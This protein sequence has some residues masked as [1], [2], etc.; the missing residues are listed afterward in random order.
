MAN[1]P[2]QYDDRLMWAASSR[3]AGL[4]KADRKRVNERLKPAWHNLK[5]Q[6][7]NREIGFL[8]I[9]KLKREISETEALA[10]ALTRSYD[11][12]IVIGI[13]GSDLGARALLRA[14]QPENPPMQVR[15]IGANTDPEEIVHLLETVDL[16]RSVL[17][18]VSKSGGTIEPMSTFLLLRDRLIRAVGKERHRHQVVATT[19]PEQGTLRT[20]VEREGY[21]SL[22]IPP[23]IGGRFS[24][25]TPVGLLPAACAGIDIR[26]LVRGAAQQFTDFL[27][28]PP[29]RNAV[30]QYAGYHHRGLEAGW[31]RLAVLMPYSAALSEIGHWYAQLWA[32]SLGK[33]RDRAGRLVHAGQTPLYAVGATDQHSQVQLFNEGPVDK[34]VTFIEVERFRHEL[35]VPKAYRDLEGLAY[36]GGHQFSDIIHAERAA[37]AQALFDAGRPNG[38]LQLTSV[39]PQ[40]VG[41]LMAF[42]MLAT[43]V[44]GELLDVNAYDQPGVEA[45]KQLMYRHLGRPGF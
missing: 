10:R 36:L 6:A 37:T 12:L 13:G 43:A 39:T 21:R 34:I 28:Q 42:F 30:L 29:S 32:E 17:N 16:K 15:F 44:M 40:S 25:L 8:E 1:N 14:L 9:P 26:Q 33:A 19:D 35:T 41:G 45:G 22:P 11:T 5:R 2:I 20:I 24:A 3:K 27:R 4:K 38:T 31:G 18:I 23:M 7:A